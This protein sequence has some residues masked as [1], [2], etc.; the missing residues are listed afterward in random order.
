MAMSRGEQGTGKHPH[1]SAEQPW[2]HTK[3]SRSRDGGGR[4]TGESRSFSD[5]KTDMSK[6]DMSKGGMSE[7]ASLKAREYRDDKGQMH[8]HT[9]TYEQQHK[10]KH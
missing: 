9:R 6:R 5:G 7:S 2:P 10:G 8:H 3:E 4:A 1:K